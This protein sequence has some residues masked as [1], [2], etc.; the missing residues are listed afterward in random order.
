MGK[1][2]SGNVDE[3]EDLLGK[4]TC[5]WDDGVYVGIKGSTGELMVADGK[6][7]WV[8]RTVRRKSSRGGGSRRT[9]R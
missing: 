5:M 3:K 6:G 8:T 2:Y 1:E 9:W 4:L 7:V